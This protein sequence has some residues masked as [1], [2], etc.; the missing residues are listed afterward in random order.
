MVGKHGVPI[1]HG[2]ARRCDTR[3]WFAA[4]GAPDHAPHGRG[5]GRLRTR[6]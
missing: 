2:R 1:L 6:L 3:R 4:G 5:A